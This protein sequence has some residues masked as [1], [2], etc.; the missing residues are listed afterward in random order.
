M[1]KD[2]FSHYTSCD[3]PQQ[4]KKNMLDL[5]YIYIK[6][7]VCPFSISNPGIDDCPNSPNCCCKNQYCGYNTFEISD[8]K[9]SQKLS[10]KSTCL[11]NHWTGL[12]I[13]CS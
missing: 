6:R 13:L 10:L 2:F 7:W 4:E 1:T 8:P 12:K 9:N 3:T 11:A 5:K